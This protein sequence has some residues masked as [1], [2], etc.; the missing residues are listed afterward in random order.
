[1]DNKA[2]D[3]RRIAEG[4]AKRPWLHKEVIKQIRKDCNIQQLK[5]GL[6]VGCGAGLSTKALKLLCEYVTGTDISPEMI[7]MCKKTYKDLSYKFY[8]SKAEENEVP[9]I[10][11]D[12][13]TAAGVINWVDKDLFLN[14]AEKI[15]S[16]NGLIVVYDFWITDRMDNNYKYTEWF[17]D[18]Y[19]KMFPKP[20]R[21]EYDWQQNDL[22]DAFKMEKKIVYD[23][24]YEFTLD[25]F[26][27]FMMIQS[28]VNEQI[29]KGI[30]TVE[31]IRNW[32]ESSLQ[33]IFRGQNKTL[34]F[35]GYNWYIRKR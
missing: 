21:K 30:L 25:E 29:E 32:M 31:E 17:Q 4:Y 34:I 11:Y 15:L 20:Y 9:A 7:S 33:P 18:K 5:N 27:D 26:I 13:I 6:D 28:N 23:L 10:L 14:N 35:E 3:S 1:M 2:F 19:L 24:K 8:V 12:I 16:S 22:S